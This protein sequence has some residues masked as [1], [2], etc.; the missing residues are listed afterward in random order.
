MGYDDAMIG[1]Q[2]V[3]PPRYGRCGT[4][5]Y[6]LSS[7]SRDGI[8]ERLIAQDP[9]LIATSSRGVMHTTNIAQTGRA[10]YCEKAPR[11]GWRS[12]IMP[13]GLDQFRE[14]FRCRL[15]GEQQNGIEADIRDPFTK[16]GVVR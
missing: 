3:S 2:D 4:G 10:E 12:F 5:T 11:R 8:M 14:M 15:G 9:M 16:A 1:P 13:T 7:K 6:T